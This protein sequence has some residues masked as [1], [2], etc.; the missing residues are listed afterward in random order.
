MSHGMSV[1]SRSVCWA[2]SCISATIDGK[3][4]SQMFK[5]SANRAF[6]FFGKL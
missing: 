6:R 4:A 2:G 3:G 5:P 1:R